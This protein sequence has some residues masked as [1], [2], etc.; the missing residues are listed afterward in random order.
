MVKPSLVALSLGF[1]LAGCS[2][3]VSAPAPVT[4]RPA[5]VAPAAPTVAAVTA[6]E[7][8][9]PD[10][11]YSYNPVGK[12]DPFRDTRDSACCMPTPPPA[13]NGPLCG[14]E[15]DQLK[16]SGVISGLANPVAVIESPQ[17]KSYRVYRGSKVGR[18]G[19]VVKQVLRDA[20]VVAEI[21]QDGQGRALEHETVIRMQPDLP[22]TLEE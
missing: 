20:L 8:S 6:V 19:G 1:L 3:R 5:S 9:V 18:N 11:S 21:T 10:V 12:P 4:S 7:S 13:C 17:G 22:M 16:L 15:L 14:Y 2:E